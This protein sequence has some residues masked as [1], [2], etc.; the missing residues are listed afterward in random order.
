MRKIS[1]F[2]KAGDTF[3]MDA[4]IAEIDQDERAPTRRPVIVANDIMPITGHRR[5]QMR[6]AA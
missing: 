3:D 6:I 1:S 4:L 2:A 5:P